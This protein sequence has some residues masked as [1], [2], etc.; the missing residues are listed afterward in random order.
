MKKIIS[1]LLIIALLFSTGI[2]T[3]AFVGEGS[4]L[5]PYLVATAEDVISISD[6]LS[7]HYKLTSDIDMTGITDFYS[8]GN[9]DDGPFTGSIDGNGKKIINLT[10]STPKE[11]YTGFVGYNE[12]NV[13]NLTL[14]NLYIDGG[15]YTGGITG[16][17]SE[18]SSVTDCSVSGTVVVKDDSAVSLNVGGVIGYNAG[19]A[20]NLTVS[21]NVTVSPTDIIYGEINVGGAIGD[22]IGTVTNVSAENNITSSHTETY[23]EVNIGGAFGRSS[24]TVEKI[25]AENN[26]KLNATAALHGEL[27]VGGVL[28]YSAGS[29]KELYSAGEVTVS[30]SSTVDKEINAGGVIANN[31]GIAESMNNDSVVSVTPLSNANMKGNIYAGGL[32]G[33]NSFELSIE[34]AINTK[35]IKIITTTEPQGGLIRCGGGLVGYSSKDIIIYDSFNSAQVVSNVNYSIPYAGGLIAYGASAVKISA[36]YNISEVYAQADNYYRYSKG[37]GWDTYG[38]RKF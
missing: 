18:D 2:T 10:I 27:S 33:Y 26:V 9:S 5:N 7:A 31:N 36:S 32:I 34:N 8:I 15:R 3:F 11:K 23:G 6:D 38:R 30:P 37:S 28:G 17:N 13:R 4:A 25:F 12:G 20:E 19:I 1:F 14:E 35:P 21:G 22:N 29:S 24:G 16:Y